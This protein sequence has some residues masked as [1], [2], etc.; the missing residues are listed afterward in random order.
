MKIYLSGPIFGRP[1][2]ESTG[3]RNNM[4]KLL[5][6]CEFL[7]P[8]DDGYVDADHPDKFD[9]IVDGDIQ[10]ITDCDVVIAMVPRPSIGTSMELW[11]AYRQGKTV[12]VITILE[13]AWL[14]KVATCIVTT[15]EAAAFWLKHL[16]NPCT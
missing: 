8:V 5:S 10:A 15:T 14:Y 11:E 3:W 12:I 1:S 9:A 2:S 6:D 4:K 16:D 7:D 13:H